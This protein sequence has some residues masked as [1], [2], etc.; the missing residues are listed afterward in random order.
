MPTKEDLIKFLEYYFGNTAAF[1]VEK[2]LK[3]M[4]IDEIAHISQEKKKEL[5]SNLLGDVISPIVSHQKLF[6]IR[7]KM[8]ILFN[9]NEDLIH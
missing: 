1:F 3:L 4:G 8:C 9:L 2:E 7:H 6:V 5:V